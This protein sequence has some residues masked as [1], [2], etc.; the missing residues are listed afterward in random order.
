M[1]VI[2]LHYIATSLEVN[3]ISTLFRLNGIMSA[4]FDQASDNIIESIKII[5]MQYEE[6]Y[7]ITARIFLPAVLF[8]GK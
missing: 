3:Q 5:V 4:Y 1:L 7:F 8:P 2:A 6:V